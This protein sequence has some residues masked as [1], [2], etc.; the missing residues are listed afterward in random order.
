MIDY[1]IVSAIA[2]SVREQPEHTILEVSLFVAY[3][4]LS[5]AAVVTAAALRSFLFLPAGLHLFH[6]AGR[7]DTVAPAR[8]I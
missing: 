8:H 4:V 3:V 5:V 6:E 1:A 7:G 2:A